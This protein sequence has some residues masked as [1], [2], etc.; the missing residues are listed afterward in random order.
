MTVY[1]NIKILFSKFYEFLMQGNSKAKALK[2]AKDYLREE[3]E[4]SHPFYWA[5]FILIGES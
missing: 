1:T 5:P 2:L 3:T 4:Y